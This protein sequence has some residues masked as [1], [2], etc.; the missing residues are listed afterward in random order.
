MSIFVS[1]F[2]SNSRRSL[3]INSKV[4]LGLSEHVKICLCDPKKQCMKIV[5]YMIARAYIV[6]FF[7]LFIYPLFLLIKI[8]RK[9]AI[10]ENE[11]ALYFSFIQYMVV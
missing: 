5:I 9:K 6:P 11:K 4:L 3:V 10:Y 8:K 1:S 7:V 2:A